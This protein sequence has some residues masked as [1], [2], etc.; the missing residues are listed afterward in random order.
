MAI[1][2]KEAMKKVVEDPY[3]SINIK[4]VHFFTRFTL[5]SNLHVSWNGSK[6]RADIYKDGAEVV[7]ILMPAFSAT[8]LSPER[9]LPR[10]PGPRGPVGICG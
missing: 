5:E 7:L 2:N 1:G 3:L 4:I 9:P 10:L 6:E 8:A